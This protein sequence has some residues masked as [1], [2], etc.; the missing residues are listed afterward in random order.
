M[1]SPPDFIE[2]F[3]QEYGYIGPALCTAVT[4]ARTQP[5]SV[6]TTVNV[7]TSQQQSITSRTITQSP[8][9]HI[10]IGSIKF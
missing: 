1:R 3:K 6:A 9:I 4:K 7:T 10:L 8:G 2:E 5:V